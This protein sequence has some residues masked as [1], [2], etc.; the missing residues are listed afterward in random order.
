M[1]SLVALVVLLTA[2]LPC[3]QIEVASA[4]IDRE[5]RSISLTAP[6][7]PDECACRRPEKGD[8]TRR[9]G[10]MLVVQISK[11][12]YRQLSGMV[13]LQGNG[14][15][16]GVLVEVFDNP[17]YLLDQS[18]VAT[19]PDQKR[20]KACVTGADGRFCFRNLPSGEY[21]LRA[22]LDQGMDVTHVYVIVDRTGGSR[23][24]IDVRLQ[25]GT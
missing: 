12:K 20:L 21:E 1:K 3:I 6:V 19:R 11:G 10:N 15:R 14:P 7:N 16:G 13:N 4:Q 22:S 18:T 24:P 17:G 2:L 5:N 25:V 9:G 8:T 23:K